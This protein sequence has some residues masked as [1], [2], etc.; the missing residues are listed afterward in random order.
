[1]FQGSS[2]GFNGTNVAVEFST[3]KLPLAAFLTSGAAFWFTV[4]TA[5]VDA[6]DVMDV[7]TRDAGWVVAAAGSNAAAAGSTF[8]IVDEVDEDEDRDDDDEDTSATPIAAA[9]TGVVMLLL[10]AACGV[11]VPDLHTL[12][13]FLDN[14]CRRRSRISL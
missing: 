9:G 4:V 6:V 3:V 14:S 8:V 11:Q 5:V 10:L 1:M 7:L 2:L 13:F 12:A